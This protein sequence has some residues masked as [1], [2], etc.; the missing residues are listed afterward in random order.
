MLHAEAEPDA[1][2][3]LKC[4]KACKAVVTTA[5]PSREDGVG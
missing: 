5:V 4:A 1:V 3:E 2:K